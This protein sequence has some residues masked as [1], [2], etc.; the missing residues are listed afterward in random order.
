[1]FFPLQW[2]VNQINYYKIQSVT[3]IV[4]GAAQRA[5]IEGF[6]T[7]ENINEMR[8]QLVESI[9]VEEGLIRI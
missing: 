3:N 9:G 4:Q 8:T 7:S 6:F 5:R 2:V 1:M